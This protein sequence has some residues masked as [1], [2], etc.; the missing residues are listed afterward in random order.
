[1]HLVLVKCLG[2]LIL[3]RES[4][5]R[6]TDRPD[7]TIA[8]LKQQHTTLKGALYKGISGLLTATFLRLLE[9]KYSADHLY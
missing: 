4:V 1:M 3:P 6:L 2:D 9:L 5:G 8:V 7:M